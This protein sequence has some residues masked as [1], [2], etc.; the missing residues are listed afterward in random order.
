MEIDA[1]PVQDVTRAAAT[2]LL[3]EN[4]VIEIERGSK[5]LARGGTISVDNR[6]TVS[7]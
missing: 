4:A 1:A 5:S 6:G 3:S 7:A 2:A